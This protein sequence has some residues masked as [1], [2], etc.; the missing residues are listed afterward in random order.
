MP[1]LLIGAALAAAAL[2]GSGCGGERARTP[3]PTPALPHFA[4]RFDPTL[5][6]PRRPRTTA[7]LEGCVERDIARTSA[8]I[9]AEARRVFALLAPAGRRAFAR[10]ERAWLA[11]RKASCT[12]ESSKYAGG[13][14]E[15]V[16]FGYCVAKQ[17]R[18]HLADLA[19]L[20]RELTR[21]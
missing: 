18:R 21:R 10:G 8:M 17:N 15:P 19:T 12:A 1:I 11:Y 20:R 9:D 2:A 16:V 13:S 5:P 6:C 7:E 3:R 4:Q 14:N